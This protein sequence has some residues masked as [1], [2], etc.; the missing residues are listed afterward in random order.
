M[1]LEDL[2]VGAVVRGIAPDGDVTV[3]AAQWFGSDAIQLT[4]RTTAG[5]VADRLVYRYDEPSLQAVR[6]GRPWS[7]DADGAD[8][9]LVAE[10]LRIRLAH[11]FDPHLAV[12]TSKVAEAR[13]L[14]RACRYASL[15]RRTNRYPDRPR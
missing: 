12:H 14:H 1:R 9:R 10:A 6:E 2:T 7:F 8:F 15:S 4:Y 13:G 11:L 3:V 5:H